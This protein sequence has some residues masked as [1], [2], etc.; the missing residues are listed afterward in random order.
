MDYLDKALILLRERAYYTSQLNWDEVITQAK[1]MTIAAQSSVDCYP[2]IHRV[3]EALGDHHSFFVGADQKDTQ[4]P[5]GTSTSFGLRILSPEWVVA[6]VFPESPASQAGI[7]TGD[8]IELIDGKSPESS[9]GRVMMLNPTVPLHLTLERD[10]SR[11]ECEMH[12]APIQKAPMPHG[13]QISGEIGYIELFVQGNPA[14]AQQY[15]DTAQQIIHD[16]STTGV[17]GWVVD[18]RRDRGGNMWPMIAGVGPLMGEG[19]LG[20]FINADQTSTTWYYMAGASSYQ[21][22]GMNAPEVVASAIS[23]V[24]SFDP[25]AT[26]VAV[27]TSEFTGSSGEMT[28]ISFLGRPNLRTFG[29]TTTGEITAVAIHEL[30]DGALLGIAESICADRSGRLYAEAIQPDEAIRVNWYRYGKN[31]D[32]VIQAAVDW[33]QTQ[34]KR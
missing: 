23:P 14:E 9:G 26:P 25:E 24:S 3:I 20:K 34:L 29:E 28:L 15:I 17:R 1:Q 27:L 2:A 31:D 13:H 4:G 7:L 12:A 10:G 11:F 30:Q 19:Q 21:Q 5:R 32:P 6:E 8:R 16:I 33:L 22:P 18:L